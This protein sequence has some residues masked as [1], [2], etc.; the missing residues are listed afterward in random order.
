V[1][2]AERH[3]DGLA[4]DSEREAAHDEARRHE[5]RLRGDQVTHA[6]RWAIR[7]WQILSA[8]ISL[9]E[10]PLR[11]PPP[12]WP[13]AGEACRLLREVVGN[14][15]RPAALDLDWLTWREGTVPKIARVIYAERRFEDLPILA[16]ALE[17]AGCTSAD[18]LGH[19]REPG[20][21]VRGCWA[22]DCI[23]YPDGG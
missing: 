15:F 14:P 21:H 18:I 6:W 2:V 5:L 1:L 4:T 17:E 12:P 19:F 23:L 16:D 11:P 9:H 10:D 22:L 8:E 20:A 13:L 3:A 7:V